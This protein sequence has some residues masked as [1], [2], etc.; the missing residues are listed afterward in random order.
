MILTASVS[1]S[2]MNH[3][4]LA[5]N[6]LVA[7]IVSLLAGLGSLFAGGSAARPEIVKPDTRKLFLFDPRVI[8]TA[9]NTRRVLGSPAKHEANPLF[10]AGKPWENSLNNLYPNVLWDED[11]QLFKLWYKCVLADKDAIARMDGPSTVHDVGWYLLHATSKDGIRW[12]KPALGLHRFDGDARTN[13][14][15]RDCP[16]A[17]VFKDSHDPDASRRYKMVSDVG[18]GKPQVRF[19]AD[20]VRWGPATSVAGFGA[21]NGDTHNNAQWDAQLGKYLWFTKLYLGERTMARF[22]SDD[23]LHWKNTGMVLRS[24]VEEGRAS[25]TYCMT[26][27][28]YGNLWLAY[29]M[30]YHPGRDRSVDCELAWSPDSAHWERLAPGK[31]FIPR[32]AKGAYDSECIY[33]MAGPPVERGGEMLIYYGGDDFPHTGWK[34]HCLP[35]LAT[36]KRDR[37]AGVEPDDAQKPATLFTRQLIVTGEPVRISADADGG[38][39]R[40]VALDDVAAGIDEAEA[41]TGSVTDFPLRWKKDG[42][43]RHAGRRIHLQIELT[44][45]CLWT[46]SGLELTQQSVPP[47]LNPLKSPHR[48]PKPAVTRTFTFDGSAEGW[49]GVDRIEHRTAGGA[50]GG[51][52]HLSRS[53]RALPIAASPVLPSESPL[54]GSLP[55]TIGGRGATIRCQVRSERPAG[56]VQIEIFARDIAQWHFETSSS[57]GPEWAGATAPLRYD[58]SDGEATKAGWRRAANAFSWA[59]TIQN[60]GKIV[61]VPTASG[62][63]DAFD[64]DEV[65]VAGE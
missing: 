16:N 48:K 4:A 2:R 33:A 31:P 54:A 15:A 25:Q 21:Q 3:S 45:A 63:L 41:V 42:L 23:F 58:W 56:K 47:V 65:S 5:S 55:E 30:L 35:C 61:I 9:Q 43:A 24:T 34:R 27:F 57:F 8:H 10:Q 20:G 59:D 51:F 11:E 29:V 38:M 14:V 39:V 64:L 60:V 49:K 53:G 1:L 37:F 50:K 22:E 40:V 19:S 36:V 26:P 12:D 44:K 6:R 62:A 32:G 46:L 17:G 13:I 28:R 7:A 18:L 52:V